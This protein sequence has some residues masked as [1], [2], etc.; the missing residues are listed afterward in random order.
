MIGGD[1]I[2]GPDSVS[3][4]PYAP[5]PRTKSPT[6][7]KARLPESNFQ[8]HSKTKAASSQAEHPV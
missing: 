1:G 6:T 7:R 5:L 3:V 8:T 4:T 2:F